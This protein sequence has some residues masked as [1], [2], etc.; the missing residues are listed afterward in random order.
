VNRAKTQ[1]P[2]IVLVPWMVAGVQTQFVHLRQKL[3]GSGIEL[4][5]NEVVPWIPGGLI[6]RLPLPAR[7]RGTIRSLVSLRGAVIPADAIWSQVALPLLP[8]LLATAPS[9]RAPVFYAIDCTPA[10]LFRLGPHYRAVTADPASAKGR[11]TTAA[12]R[13]FFRRCAGLLPWSAWAARS[14]IDDYGAEPAKV[15]VLPPGIDTDR[16]RPSKEPAPAEKVRLLF[17]GA[18]FARKGGPLLLNLYRR[19]LRDSCDLSLVTREDVGNEPGVTVHRGYAPDDIGLVR[20]FQSSDILVIPTL[21]DC[22]SM[23]AIEAMACGLPVVTT[24]VGG[25]PEIV[26]DGTTGLLVKPGDGEGLLHS[27]RRLASDRSTRSRLGRSGREVVVRRFNS[28]VQA[29]RTIELMMD[30]VPSPD[31]RRR[32]GTELAEAARSGGRSA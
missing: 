27:I 16:W 12:Y 26:A 11:V 7:T 10:L 28:V 19:F 29:R 17:V 5:I 32:R 20:L 14:M 24:S 9:R 13:A 21:A 15:H 31:N 18:D 6:E 30:G 3:K 8:H 23:A 1:R 2:H 4:S 25:I 22:F